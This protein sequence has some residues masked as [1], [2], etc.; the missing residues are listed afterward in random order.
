MSTRKVQFSVTPKIHT[1][2]KW[3]FAYRQSRKGVWEEIA[4]DRVRFQRRIQKMEKIISR[5]LDEKHRNEIKKK[6]L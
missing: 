1:L 5:V 4:R 3:D 6:I 2:Y